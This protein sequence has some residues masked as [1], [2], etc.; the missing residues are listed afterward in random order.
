MTLNLK[1]KV[2]NFILCESHSDKV[3]NFY[4]LDP[5]LHPY[6]LISSSEQALEV[7]I[8]YP[9]LLIRTLRIGFLI[10]ER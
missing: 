3:G 7:E 8:K 1:W 4:M 5:A 10:S 6:D 2:A 9:I